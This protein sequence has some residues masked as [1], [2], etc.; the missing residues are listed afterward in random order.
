MTSVS[1]ACIVVESV[2]YG[3]G[4]ITASLPQTY[5][6]EALAFL[7]NVDGPHSKGCNNLIRDSV[8]GLI[9][10]VYD[11]VK[12]MGWEDDARLNR[13]YHEGIERQLFPDLSAEESQVIG[14]SGR[15]NDL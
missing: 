12:S 2:A 11:F 3:G 4:P 1:D 14:A 7:D 15:N 13:T 8:V 5:N 6:R 10:H 9:S